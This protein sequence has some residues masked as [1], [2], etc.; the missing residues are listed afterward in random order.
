[1]LSLPAKRAEGSKGRT[2]KKT[3]RLPEYGDNIWREKLESFLVFPKGSVP[4][5]KP[6]RGKVR[7]GEEK[8]KKGR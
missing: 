6:D 2:E 1:V 5:R 4:R 7:V 8:K 3:E